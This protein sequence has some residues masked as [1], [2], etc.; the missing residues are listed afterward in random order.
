MS[1]RELF[2][3]TVHLCDA[4]GVVTH[5]YPFEVIASVEDAS[6]VAAGF[7]ESGDWPPVPEGCAVGVARKELVGCIKN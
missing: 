5:T 4:S 3:W 2:T 6:E 1:S 7:V